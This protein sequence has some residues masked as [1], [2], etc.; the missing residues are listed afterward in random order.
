MARSRGAVALA[1]TL[2]GL[3][4]TPICDEYRAALEQVIAAK[5]TGECLPTR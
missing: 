2:S 1:E 5:A 3:G 4:M